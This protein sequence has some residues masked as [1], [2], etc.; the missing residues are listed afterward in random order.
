VDGP[1]VMIHGGIQ[2]DIPVGSR[3]SGGSVGSGFVGGGGGGGA[4][5]VRNAIAAPAPAGGGAVPGK[6]VMGK[7][8]MSKPS[9]SG[10]GM[11][12]FGGGGGGGGGGGDSGEALVV[13]AIIAIAIAAFAAVGLMATEGQRYDGAVSMSPEQPVHLKLLSGEERVL[14][15][16][17]LRPED[18]ASLDEALVMDDEGP[19]LYLLG[20]APLDR[21]GWTFKLD[22]GSSEVAFQKYLMSG[23]ASNIQLGYFPFQN[24]G[25]LG[26]MSLGFGTD[27]IDNRQFFRNFFGV[28]AQAFLPGVSVFHFGTYLNAGNRFVQY[29]DAEQSRPAVGAGAL[30]EIELT[31]RMA[32]T[33]RA[34]WTFTNPQSGGWDND[35]F[36]VGAGISI[37]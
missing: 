33:A 9:S 2:V 11:P 1:N 7:P 16:G 17:D 25:L 34:G 37:Y 24:L 10:G 29:V 32:L 31:T 36:A 28:E 6:A 27:D 21:K 22:F 19:G 3:R 13:F 30:L 18:L 26:T 4:G 14:R 12:S 15:L 20:R 23:F 35:G 5:P 8:A